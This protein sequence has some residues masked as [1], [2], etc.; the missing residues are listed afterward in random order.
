MRVLTWS[1]WGSMW[2][3]SSWCRRCCRDGKWR[4]LRC[5]MRTRASQKSRNSNWRVGSCRSGVLPPTASD[6]SGAATCCRSA[7]SCEG[8]AHACSSTTG[9]ITSHSQLTMTWGPLL[10]FHS[11]LS[12]KLKPGMRSGSSMTS[13]LPHCN[14]RGALKRLA[15]PCDEEL[16][17]LAPGCCFWSLCNMQGLA[18]HGPFHTCMLHTSAQDHHLPDTH[19]IKLC[20]QAVTAMP[21]CVKPVQAPCWC[22]SG[23]SQAQEH[24]SLAL[25]A[26]AVHLSGL[27]CVGAG[28]SPRA[29][30]AVCCCMC[31]ISPAALCSRTAPHYSTHSRQPAATHRAHE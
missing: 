1:A 19:A 17:S 27:H 23:S 21:G 16:S 12:S 8:G 4:Y 30:P 20:C 3:C 26:T 6:T 15:S 25:A 7:R 22:V 28:P 18:Q 29:C 13:I 10:C 24:R 14:L 5:A 31:R 2:L 11:H 9:V